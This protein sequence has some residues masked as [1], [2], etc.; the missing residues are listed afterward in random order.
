MDLMTITGLAL[1]IGAVYYVLSTG[2]ILGILFN[3]GS[4]Y[5]LEKFGAAFPGSKV[6]LRFILNTRM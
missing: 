6:C 2:G 5:R 3:I 4:L 1:G